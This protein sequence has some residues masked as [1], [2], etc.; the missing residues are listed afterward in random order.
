MRL[1]ILSSVCV[2]IALALFIQLTSFA[3]PASVQQSQA[4]ADHATTLPAA[5]RSFS[6]KLTPVFLHDSPSGP[7]TILHVELTGA[8]PNL[9]LS[10][11]A[12]ANLVAPAAADRFLC[13]AG[14]R[15]HAAASLKVSLD[16][17]SSASTELC[18]SSEALLLA[19]GSRVS[20]QPQVIAFADGNTTRWDFTGSHATADLVVPGIPSDLASSFASGAAQNNLTHAYLN[21]P[22]NLLV[23]AEDASTGRRISAGSLLLADSSTLLAGGS[24]VHPTVV[25]A[26]AAH[27]SGFTDEVTALASAPQLLNAASKGSSLLPASCFPAKPS[28][29]TLFRNVWYSFTPI[30]NGL[31]SFRTTGSRFDTA[32]GVF[33]SNGSE[34]QLHACND[35]VV[36][37]QTKLARPQAEILHFPVQ[38]GVTYLILTGE[39]SPARGIAASPNAAAQSATAALS[40]DAALFFAVTEAAAAPAV[41][42]SATSLQFNTQPLGTTSAQQTITV[43][44]SGGADL[45]VSTLTV[46][47]GFVASN[48]CTAAVAPG[49]TCAIQVTFQ[50][51]VTGDATNNLL[52]TDNA[53]DSPQAVQLAGMGTD[54]FLKSGAA[55][56]NLS[57]FGP[58]LYSL[59][60]T[61]TASFAS[62][63]TFTCQNLPVNVQCAFNPATATA[64]QVAVP[65]DLTVSRISTT[66]QNFDVGRFRPLFAI[67]TLG[68]VFLGS[69]KSL[70]KRL[71]LAVLA[72][73]LFG[74]SSCGGSSTKPQPLP[75]LGAY[76]FQ[77]VPTINGVALSNKTVNLTLNVTAQ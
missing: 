69:R 20:L 53:A 75:A 5:D 13:G 2:S 62:T 3:H 48:G 52:I 1:R 21:D 22:R 66:A 63:V 64:Q 26:V 68:F 8:A 11:L 14:S 44:N 15:W 31:A 12:L 24:L 77:V 43:T 23:I 60:L 47:S 9:T 56:A 16:G 38:K 25:D 72:L 39:V 37:A 28:N 51:V 19:N 33:T 70:R 50:P 45:N 7:A 74:I 27:S 34:L 42:L 35:D 55:S 58:A 4:I 41:T 73:M 30:A 46:P 61:G 32:L 54:F 59:S 49:R 29:T 36:D 40:S 17:S 65:V 6:V 71:G 76:P 18:A 67:L 10:S 57:P